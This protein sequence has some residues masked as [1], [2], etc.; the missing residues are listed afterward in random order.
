MS[1]KSRVLI[2]SGI[3]LAAVVL[4]LIFSPIL[5]SKPIEIEFGLTYQD[6]INP[7]DT[8]GIKDRDYRG[9]VY[10]FNAAADETYKF[11]ASSLSDDII[12]VYEYYEG[13]KIQI[14]RIEAMGSGEADH[15]FHSTGRKIIC[16]EALADACPADYSLRVTK[17]EE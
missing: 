15:T 17:V 9:H 10:S 1:R 5:K 3:V 2:I 12:L 11:E 7:E 13:D 8:P 4:I 6:T 16:V 14:L